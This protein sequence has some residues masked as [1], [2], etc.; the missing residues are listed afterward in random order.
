MPKLQKALGAATYA[1]L[2]CLGDNGALRFG[3]LLYS[4]PN[5]RTLSLGLS[6]LLSRDLIGKTPEGL[7]RLTAK[8]SIVLSLL[9]ELDGVLS[10]T[11]EPVFRWME[12]EKLNPR[13]FAPLIAEYTKTLYSMFGESL[14]AVAIFGSLARG[15]AVINQSDID[16]LI[17]V[18]GWSEPIWDRLEQL[19]IARSR[20][21]EKNEYKLLLKRKIWPLIREYPL[22]TEE[23]K[24]F[25]RIYLDMTF[26]RAIVYDKEDFLTKRLEQ[27][28]G[29]LLKLGARRVTL[30]DGKWYWIL[31]SGLSMGDTLQL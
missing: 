12:L 10:S 3:E 24:E 18:D 17:I 25:H 21:R 5:P 7:Y 26:D 11:E 30:P 14:R 16:L 27:L 20:L 23:A 28:S 31:K 19:K 6:D 8:G 2:Q 4:V 13:V 29:Q 1:I 9:K 22:S 15:D